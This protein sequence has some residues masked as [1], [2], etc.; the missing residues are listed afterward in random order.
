[1]LWTDKLEIPRKTSRRKVVAYIRVSTKPQA[2]GP[3]LDQQLEAI[4][5][6]ASRNYMEILSVH[7]D[8]KSAY[9]QGILSRPGL[10]D[11]VHAAKE[12][13][14]ALLVLNAS[15]L[16]RRLDDIPRLQELGVKIYTV[17]EG[18]MTQVKLCRAVEKA[19]GEGAAKSSAQKSRRRT[20]KVSGAL[21]PEQRGRGAITARL[22]D[23]DNIHAAAKCLCKVKGARDMTYGERAHALSAAGIVKVVNCSGITVNWTGESLRKAWP[24]IRDE[25]DLLE[26]DDPFVGG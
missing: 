4:K 18:L 10:Q 11:A 3:S 19:Q 16:T 1:M 13:N 20:Q 17:D 14:A 7:E 24:R 15:R 2:D 25:M 22:R 23:H 12:A 9:R 5:K 8:T 6:H 26:E 21:T